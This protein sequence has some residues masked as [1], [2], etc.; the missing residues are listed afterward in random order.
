VLPDTPS[1][2]GRP[3]FAWMPDSRR[4]VV[5]L[6]PIADAPP[7]I[8]I[9]DT[10]SGKH[11]AVTSGTASQ[12]AAAVSPDGGKLVLSEYAGN[13]D[14]VSVDL[15]TAAARRLI[16]TERDES[17][18]AWGVSQPV[19]VY[20]T[21]RNGPQEIWLRSADG[22]SRPVVTARDFP[23]GTTQFFMAPA[24][25]PEGARVVY[26]RVERNGDIRL[27]MSAVAG[28]APVQLTSDVGATEFPGSFSPDGTWFAYDAIENGKKNLRKVKVSG[29]AAS[30]LVKAGSQGEVPVWS[31][32]GEWILAGD[33]LVSPD[34]QTVRPLGDR[35]TDTY[36]FSAN[37]KLLYG[38][39]SVGERVVLFS[40]DIATG[41]ETPIGNAGQEFS[42]AS[43]F[44]PAIRYSLAPDGKSIVFG[45]GRF[46]T[47]LWMLEGFAP[48]A[49]LLMRFGLR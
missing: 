8:W 26:T 48:K 35:H 11:I 5:L 27:W 1:Y 37:G 42:P 47:N 16:A 28:G 18:R 2:G 13:Y 3:N 32:T 15:D 44:H 14:V 4:V 36:A 22:A 24:L 43:N 41:A 38:L 34:G 21:D 7:Q 25:S 46:K 6:R 40:V 29:Q 23:P 9:A 49:G 17:M 30:T 39:R 19:L 31:P 33:E 45:A 12:I 20:V 10:V